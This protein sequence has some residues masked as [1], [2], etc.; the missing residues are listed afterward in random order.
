MHELLEKF[1]DD[2]VELSSAVNEVSLIWRDYPPDDVFRVGPERK[3]ESVRRACQAALRN[4]KKEAPTSY[5][6]RF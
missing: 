3:T 6:A 1:Q 4:P 2:W 5:R